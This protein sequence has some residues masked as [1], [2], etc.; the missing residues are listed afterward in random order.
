MPKGKTLFVSDFDDTLAQTDARVFVI[1]NGKR[2]PMSPEQYAVYQERPGD[3]FDFSEFNELKNPR[4]I[5][6]FSKLLRAAV[7]DKKAD[8]VVVLTARGHTRPVAQFL[9]MIGIKTGV[10]IAALG[11]SDPQKKA[12]YI[13]KHIQRDGY[14][15]V[16]FVDDS[17]K[18][19]E[20]VR[21]L[22]KKHPKVKILAHQAT[23]GEHKPKKDTPSQ[24]AKSQ[25]LEYFGFG[26]YGKD[27]KVTHTVKD[28]KLQ[29]V[30]K[31]N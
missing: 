11:S 1:R 9:K 23:T 4:P 15:R 24:Q 14:D 21:A 29:K 22:Q 12:D 16:A 20:A 6:R 7:L 5:I 25:G 31:K 17:P 19:I 28:G 26:R 8:K 10:S 18:N 3:K 2:I 13:D 27:G 30:I